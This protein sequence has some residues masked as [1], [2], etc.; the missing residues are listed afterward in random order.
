[1]AFVTLEKGTTLYRGATYTSD[2]YETKQDCDVIYFARDKKTAEIYAG[3]KG[4]NSK[5]CVWEYETEKDITLLCLYDK[6]R[7][8]F[9]NI[10]LNTLK[11]MLH[12]EIEKK[13]MKENEQG[14]DEQNSNNDTDEFF[15][16]DAQGNKTCTDANMERLPHGALASVAEGFGLED[17]K[18]TSG[19]TR[20]SY[21]I[22]DILFLALMFR[23]QFG[24]TF[25]KQLKQIFK[26]FASCKFDPVTMAGKEE[27]IE[28]T[29]QEALAQMKLCDE[30]IGYISFEWPMGTK[31]EENGIT[32]EV[33]FHEELCLQKQTGLLKFKKA[34]KIV[35]NKEIDC[36]PTVGGKGRKRNQKKQKGGQEILDDDIVC[37]GPGLYFNR[38]IRKNS[39]TSPNPNYAYVSPQHTDEVKNNVKN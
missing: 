38:I 9:H 22:Y 23:S 7:E 31:I 35:D 29:K 15:T 25:R 20:S 10:I 26:R 24:K 3:V 30:Y 19:F 18:K 36:L 21:M 33:H 6:D 11:N 14:D 28:K 32:K 4:G 34:Y 2:P 13:K 12:A 27:E 17:P 16:I 39:D 8:L 37:P 5:G 1:M